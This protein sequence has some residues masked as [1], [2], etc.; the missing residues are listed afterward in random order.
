VVIGVPTESSSRREDPPDE[1]APASGAVFVYDRAHL[2]ADPVQ[3]IKAPDIEKGAAFGGC[4]ALSGS[5]LA[6]GAP[7]EAHRGTPRTGAIYVYEQ[8][9]VVSNFKTV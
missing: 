7:G 8:G 5:T 1:A 9:P 4:V 6:I 3:Y 2:D